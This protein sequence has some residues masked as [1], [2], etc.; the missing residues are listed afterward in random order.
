[1]KQILFFFSVLMGF[2]LYSQ[3]NEKL[4]WYKNNFDKLT[5]QVDLGKFY[6]AIIDENTENTKIDLEL[7][8]IVFKG[9]PGIS[10]TP[11]DNGLVGTIHLDNLKFP[12]IFQ[13]KRSKIYPLYFLRIATAGRYNY[14]G[15]FLYTGTDFLY[16]KEQT[17]TGGR[18]DKDRYKLLMQILLLDNEFR[19][20]NMIDLDLGYVS[21]IERQNLED[22]FTYR[23]FSVN[24]E[25]TLCLHYKKNEITYKPE[26]MNVFINLLKEDYSQIKCEP[27]NQFVYRFVDST[28]RIWFE[29]GEGDAIVPLNRQEKQ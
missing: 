15:P 28:R 21:E 19:T 12:I 17:A 4:A 3:G 24:S 22:H 6:S 18:P 16:F 13:V 7:L 23:V 2:S 26:L 1:M 10:F 27:E 29:I 11:A 8:E 20:K 25:V 5:N 9:Y 14:P